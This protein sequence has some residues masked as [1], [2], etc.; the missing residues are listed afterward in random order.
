VTKRLRVLIVSPTFPYP[1]A[2]GFGMRVY[3]LAR[4]LAAHHDVTLL[5]YARADEMVHVD[6]LREQLGNVRVVERPQSRGLTKRV[7]QL[8]SIAS[9]T[10]YQL[11]DLYSVEMQSAIDELLSRQTFDIIQFESSQM[12]GFRCQSKGAVVLDEH[13]IE[14]ELLQR[15]QQGERSWNRR[16]YNRVE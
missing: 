16:L 8:T 12:C 5:T 10:S 6:T 9:T 15:M 11:R 14:Y 7:A 1:P 3:Q 2:W 13:N 4:Y